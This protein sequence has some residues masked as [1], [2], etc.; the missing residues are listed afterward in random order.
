LAASK[1]LE[2]IIRDGKKGVAVWWGY[3]S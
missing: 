3:T 2:E 1:V